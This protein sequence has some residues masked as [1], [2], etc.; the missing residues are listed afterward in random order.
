ML[1]GRLTVFMPSPAG[2]E[3]SLLLPAFARCR[4]RWSPWGEQPDRRGMVE[5][6]GWTPLRW[7]EG[8]PASSPGS[9][10]P[11]LNG[12]DERALVILVT[13]EEEVR[14]TVLAAALASF[15]RYCR[16]D[17]SRQIGD[18][19]LVRRIDT[20]E[21]IGETMRLASVHLQGRSRDGVGYLGLHLDATWSDD[22]GVGVILHGR[23]VVTI[24]TADIVWCFRGEPGVADA[25]TPGAPMNTEYPCKPRSV[26]LPALLFAPAAAA[27]AGM[28]YLALTTDRV[29][30]SRTGQPILDG[31]MAKAAFWGAAAFITA[32][33]VLLAYGAYVALVRP[34]PRIVLSP[35]GITLPR[36]AIPWD[37][38]FI[39][40]NEVSGLAYPRGMSIYG[41]VPEVA[42]LQLCTSRGTFHIRKSDLSDDGFTEV[43]GLIESRVG[44][45]MRRRQMVGRGVELEYPYG[46]SPT[47]GGVMVAV[48]VAVTALNAYWAA[49]SN[50]PIR[51]RDGMVTLDPPA[52]TKARWLV[53]G[54]FGLATLLV[55]RWVWV[56]CFLRRRIALARDGLYCSTSGWLWT[57]VERFVPYAEM[58]GCRLDI[59]DGTPI[60]LRFTHAGREFDIRRGLLPSG[61]FDEVSRLIAE[62]ARAGPG[63]TT[64]GPDSSLH[65]GPALPDAAPPDGNAGLTTRDDPYRRG[66]RD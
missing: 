62:R 42:C 2:W 10:A 14:R 53:T 55:G 61:A 28:V 45:A 29:V 9:P 22:H 44:D 56:D 4:G 32:V 3:A 11:T 41:E 59:K 52:A 5:R 60:R 38:V 12:A 19:A 39:D 49:T 46:D 43:C 7:P 57:P 1:S 27:A 37:D 66:T 20:E 24:E 48:L 25:A 64:A 36:D 54:L 21:G 6:E 15:R 58:G 17:F 63:Q 40:Y 50:E 13:H 47:A 34:A 30:D 65:F 33:A 18:E 51:G 26:A 8:V 31:V 16:S 35:E 23:R